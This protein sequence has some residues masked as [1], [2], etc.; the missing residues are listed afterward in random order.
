MSVESPAPP[1]LLTP[2]RSL[3]TGPTTVV[4]TLVSRRA[5]RSVLPW[6]YVFAIYVVASISGYSATY[7]TAAAR[8]K[9]ARSLAPNTGIRALLGPARH[10]DSVA[11]FAAWRALGVL[12]LV[13]A[14]WA[15]LAA[16]RLLRG[17]EDAG[18]W[19]LLLAGQTTRRRAAAQGLVGL[20]IGWA[21]LWG[22]TAIASVIDGR[23]VH[24]AFS[25]RASL[26]FSLAI[27]AS[28]AIF[29]A[30]G[31]VASQLA[32]T[33]RQAATLAGGVLG[34]S[35][36]IRMVADSAS[37][38]RWALWASPLGWVEELRPLT[39][40]R[41]VMLVPI[42]ALV[43]VLSVVTV[44]LADERDV[45]AS[46]LPDRD[47]AP[48]RT[49]LLGSPTGLTIRL[50]RPVAIGWI[51]AIA[52]CGLLF[53]LVA[54]S[55]ANAA[56]GSTTVQEALSRLGGRHGGAAAYLGLTFVIVATL[57]ALVAAGQVVAGREEE[58]EGRLDNI[59][60][61]PYP[62]EGW[63]AGR[64]A[65]AVVL[66]IGCGIAAGVLAW[67]GAASQH[68]GLGFGS[69][70]KAGINTVPPAL[71]VLGVGALVH[72]TLP[73]LTGPAVYGVVA[74]SFL[75]EFVGSI[76]KTNRWLLDTSV[77]YH[78]APAPATNPHWDS[79]A[80]LGLLGVAAAVGGTFLFARRDL[81]SA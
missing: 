45:G 15:L 28:A 37:G 54:Q 2:P 61:R 53:G 62:R 72:A 32:A 43:A 20:T 60:V 65:V 68:S 40:S 18:R 63:L 70:I 35:F 58:A 41:P 44:R 17:E 75:I 13:G 31:A 5:L 10:I 1:R 27:T 11:G 55:A 24:P 38:L 39:G 57:I 67:V 76:V 74:W 51:A 25:V 23:T 78:V 34:A 14:V 47:T 30:V 21:G 50:M 48:P 81:V 36:V 56:S 42:G 66:L 4:A 80:V 33:R 7:K 64:L 59:V 79:A 6:C 69:L 46:I 9:L 26:F 8:E 71:F 19:E 73:R 29:L 3:G 22:V 49:R 16:T 12:S 52:A 77:L